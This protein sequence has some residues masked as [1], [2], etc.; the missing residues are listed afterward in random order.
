MSNAM[1]VQWQNPLT[2][3]TAR[4]GGVRIGAALDK[5]EQNLEAIRDDCVASLDGLL[6]ELVALNGG[7][8]PAPPDDVRREIYRIAN[9]IHGMAGVFGLPE[10]GQ[11]AYS[12]CEL[13]DRLATL[14]R[15]HQPSVDVH[16]A[17]LQLLRKPGSPEETAKLLERLRAL[18]GHI[19]I[20]ATP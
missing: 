4:P 15:W 6:A 3:I 2:A 9:E 12:L 16:L 1:F 7:G 14:G 8:A 17:A 11:A 13:V 18:T 5:A 19:D 10:L 20:I